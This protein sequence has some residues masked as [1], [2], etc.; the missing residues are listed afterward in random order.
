MDNF[1]LAWCGRVADDVIDF[2]AGRI[3]IYLRNDNILETYGAYLNV[4]PFWTSP[5]GCLTG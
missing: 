3:N 4:L 1:N 5:R 2:A